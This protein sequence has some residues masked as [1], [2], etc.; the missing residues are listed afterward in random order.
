LDNKNPYN[1]NTESNDKRLGATF[2]IVG[3]IIAIGLVVIL[4]NFSLF[5][6][7]APMISS[8]QVGTQITISRD[9]DSHFRLKGSV[10]GIPVTFLLDTGASSVAV[11]AQ[12]AK[13][14]GLK[15]KAELITE[16]ANGSA[17]GYYTVI[18][19][20]MLANV[21][22]NNVSA[23]IVPNMDS[24]QALLGMN[25]LQHFEITQTKET[26]LLLVPHK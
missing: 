25:V 23:V 12:L 15:H 3:W 9:Y 20:I 22:L 13:R 16:T 4:V 11:S 26:M 19:K 2:L 7:K 18:D 21:E 14:A 6:T 5:G 8:S 1:N 17:V 24:D 10:N